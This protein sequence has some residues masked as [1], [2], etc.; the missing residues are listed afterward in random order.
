MFRWLSSLARPTPPSGRATRWSC[1]SRPMF[2]PSVE[3]LEERSLLNSAPMTFAAGGV[4]FTGVL[5]TLA[6]PDL[7]PTGEQFTAT[8]TY[9]DGPNTNPIPGLQV[10]LRS[11]GQLDF[12]VS[13]LTFQNPG[14]STATFTI[15][16]VEDDGSGDTETATAT[17]S[18]TA[19]EAL[20]FA[21]NQMKQLLKAEQ[22]LLNKMKSS[23]HPTLRLGDSILTINRGNY[24]LFH[25]L[26][27]QVT[28]TSLDTPA[29]KKLAL[30][31][32]DTSE[33]VEKAGYAFL[34]L[35]G[36]LQRQHI[37]FVPNSNP[38]G[39][40]GLAQIAAD[41]QNAKNQSDELKQALADLKSSLGF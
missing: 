35:A 12:L 31:F 37:H 20:N 23:S 5:T 41:L 30:E 28:T 1:H 27:Y 15:A 16:E 8:G 13:N 32:L 17:F 9:T 2:R 14:T 19:P 33:K 18:V 10:R 29:F 3:G 21:E 11:D 36:A 38:N 7:D 34:K 6:D 24:V 22:V 39:L 26:V 40:N 25:D 4:P